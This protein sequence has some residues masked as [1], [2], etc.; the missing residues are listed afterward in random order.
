MTAKL[1]IRTRKIVENEIELSEDDISLVRSWLVDEFLSH[2]RFHDYKS[3]Y[4]GSTNLQQ[5]KFCQKFGIDP[6]IDADRIEFFKSVVG[7]VL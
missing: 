1:T 7:V 6:E 3:C 4:Q 2:V 5:I